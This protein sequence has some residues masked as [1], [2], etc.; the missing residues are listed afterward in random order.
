MC[1]YFPVAVGL[2]LFTDINLV[3]FFLLPRPGLCLESSESMT[4]SLWC[5]DLQS[6]RRRGEMWPYKTSRRALQPLSVLSVSLSD[7]SKRNVSET[8]T[9]QVDVFTTFFRNSSLS[10]RRHRFESNTQQS[11]HLISHCVPHIHKKSFIQLFIFTHA[12]ETHRIVPYSWMFFHTFPIDPRLSIFFTFPI[13]TV[14][15]SP[16]FPVSQRWPRFLLFSTVCIFHTFPV[17][18]IFTIFH[19]PHR[20]NSSQCIPC[21]PKFPYVSHFPLILHDLYFI[22]FLHFP[23]ISSIRY[24]LLI[25]HNLSKSP[26]NST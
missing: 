15:V 26:N 4:F 3:R 22:P 9:R 6:F 19:A 20:L 8:G 18:P 13:F 21:C 2:A 24:L 10:G 14:L 1:V 16:V 25:P 12:T 11:D 17:F 23:D 5:W 7:A